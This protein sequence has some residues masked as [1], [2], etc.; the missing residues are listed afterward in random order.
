MTSGRDP[1]ATTL[2]ASAPAVALNAAPAGTP[3]IF[4]FPDAGTRSMVFRHFA[5]RAGGDFTVLGLDPLGLNGQE[6]PFA[7]VE[8][9]AQAYAAGIRTA[10]PTG[11]VHLVGHAFGALTAFA[12]AQSL[13]ATGRAIASLSLFDPPLAPWGGEPS[14]AKVRQGFAADLSAPLALQ[15][16]AAE[17]STADFITSLHRALACSVD[18]AGLAA[19]FE[20]VRAARQIS[21]APT[22]RF[23]GEGHLFVALGTTDRERTLQ[24]AA[25]LGEMTICVIAAPRHQMLWPDHAATLFRLWRHSAGTVPRRP[26]ARTGAMAGDGASQDV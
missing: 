26:D 11:A 18:V 7:S 23:L 10:A 5:V 2:I 21:Y 6:R 13:E 25:L 20:T 15:P 17:A 14:L 22:R 16:S 19:R 1:P 9:A 24:W 3:T 8:M 4:V 12:T